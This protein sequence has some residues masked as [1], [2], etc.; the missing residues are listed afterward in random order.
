MPSWV[1]DTNVPV[2][3]NARV[4]HASPAC[5]R[6]CVQRLRD[7]QADGRVVIDDG[8]RIMGEYM[9]NLSRS[10]QPGAGDVFMKWVW[11]HQ[12]VTGKCHQ[13]AIT[14]RDSGDDFQ[15]FPDDPRLGGFDPADRK[16]VAV[17]RACGASPS[18]LN[19]VDS[20]WWEY[21]DVLNEYGVHVEFLCQEQ[22][23]S[24][25]GELRR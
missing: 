14:L 24:G 1:I 3:A 25:C 4:T 23:D 18:V 5:I 2:V 7:V 21:R 11:Q 20:D 15:E 8:Y 16:F 10:G 13:V 17:A 9:R 22:F 6:R 19:A 12:A